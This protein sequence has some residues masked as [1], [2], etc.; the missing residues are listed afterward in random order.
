[1]GN[2]ICIGFRESVDGKEFRDLFYY[3][4]NMMIPHSDIR[5][6]YMVRLQSF[7]KTLMETDVLGKNPKYIMAD[8][9][10]FIRKMLVNLM[11]TEAF[12][13]LNFY[14]SCFPTLPEYGRC[15]PVFDTYSGKVLIYDQKLIEMLESYT[16]EEYLAID[17]NKKYEKWVR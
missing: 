2:R 6:Y 15:I 10:A 16:L 1:M 17:F 13:P 7:F 11:G 8:S 5:D 9:S 4:H 14:I 3:S 12:D